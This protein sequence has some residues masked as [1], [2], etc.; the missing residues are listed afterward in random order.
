MRTFDITFSP[1]KIKIYSCP[2]LEFLDALFCKICGM[3][4]LKFFSFSSIFPSF[5]RTLLFVMNQKE[6]GKKKIK[7]LCFAIWGKVDL[8]GIMLHSASFLRC[9][10]TLCFCLVN[11]P[12]GIMFLLSLIFLATFYLNK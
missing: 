9:C 12:V 3:Q 6:I 1:R 5:S 10:D 8:F 7:E 4:R 2:D 11:Y